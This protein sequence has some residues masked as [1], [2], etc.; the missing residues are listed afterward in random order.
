VAAGTI[1]GGLLSPAAGRLADR[2]APRWLLVAGGLA[3]GATSLG[4]AGIVEPW[5]FYAWYVPARIVAQTLLAVVPV[6]LVAGWFVRRRPRALGAVAMA[7][8]L[9]S[10]MLAPLY[11]V[12]IESYGWR[13]VFV[14]LGV[15]AL[16]GLCPLAALLVRRP[17]ADLGAEGRVDPRAAERAPR[18][19]WTSGSAL[20]TAAVWLLSLAML[21]ANL[22]TGSVGLNLAAAL[23]DQGISA[24]AASTAAGGFALAGAVASLVWGVLAERVPARWLLAGAEVAA[25]AAVVALPTASTALQG[26]QLAVTLG[27]AARGQQA[28]ATILIAEYYGPRAFGALAGVVLAAQTVALGLGP[29]AASTAYDLTG[30]YADAFHALGAAYL[31]AAV[32]VCVARPPRPARD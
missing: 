20:R 1:A 11:E 9:G 12:V 13:A 29:L 2:F 21:C 17:P 27:A 5:Q 7:A 10:A 15:L 8:P 19:Q 31:A 23:T 26:T 6:V 32:L 22:A 25:A 16:V 24:T 18:T 30:S 28:L 3:L 14:V 4:L